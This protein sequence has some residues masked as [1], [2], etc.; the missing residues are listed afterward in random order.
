MPP[1]K[2]VMITR[3]WLAV[4]CV[5]AVAGGAALAAASCD[6]VPPAERLPALAAGEGPFAA[7]MEAH[8]GSAIVGGNRVEV[9]LNGDQI[10]PAKLAA[11]RAARRTITYA[12][13]FYADDG[14]ARPITE[15][16]AERCRAGVSAHVLLDGFGTL[17]MPTEYVET[18][19]QAGCQVA[20]FRPLGRFRSLGR[21]NKRNHRRILVVDGRVGITGGSGVSEKWTGDGRTDGH[22][23]DTDLEIEGPAVHALQSAF[24]ENWREATGELLGGDGYF[25]ARPRG[26]AR[27]QVI[28]SSPAG[29]SYAMHTM[30]MLAI[31]AARRSVYLTNPYF[32]PDERMEEALLGA[33]ARGV[34]VVALTPGKIDHNVVRA[35]SRR[36][37][38]RLLQGGIQIFEYQ[39][40]LLHAK[41]M[42]VD[43]VWATVGSTNFDNRSFALNDEL[44]VVL[45]DRASVAPLAGAFER[46]LRHARSV[47]YAAWQA[48]GLRTKLLELFVLPIE[49]QL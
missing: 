20:I 24:V 41:T 27:A 8:T 2:T 37:F 35:A 3:R 40:A 19:R 6:R 12:E 16:L 45:Y 17:S 5:V 34:R 1:A 13:Y 39:A 38:G 21:H 47:T 42:V 26:D 18:L 7:T 10:F 30:Y 25:A 23:R 15:A 49:S 11:I 44:N 14:P 28:R 32:L 36:G 33:A 22:W 9:L 46:D 31:A 4:A 29:G 43:G 48:R